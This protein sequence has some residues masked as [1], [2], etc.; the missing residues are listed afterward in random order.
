MKASILLVFIFIGEKTTDPGVNIKCKFIAMW[1]ANHQ[2]SSLFQQWQQI[3]RRNSFYL[4]E[5][6]NTSGSRAWNIH[7]EYPKSDHER[8]HR[9][10]CTVL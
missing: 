10:D 8:D 7:G 9:E 5:S 2:C 3:C 4:C 6:E 1:S